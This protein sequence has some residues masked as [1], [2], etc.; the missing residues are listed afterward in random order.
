[1]GHIRCPHWE[2]Y[3]M[4]AA[5]VKRQ[6]ERV[7]DDP[8]PDPSQTWNA[9]ADAIDSRKLSQESNLKMNWRPRTNEWTP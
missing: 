8:P 3:T 2:L 9:K 7:D 6:V 5:D 1:M 4:A